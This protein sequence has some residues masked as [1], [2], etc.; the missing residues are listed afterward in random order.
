[1]KRR[2]FIRKSSSVVVSSVAGAY[3]ARAYNRVNSSLANLL[4]YADQSDRILVM[5]F[6]NGGNDGLNTVVPLAELSRLSNSRPHVLLPEQSLLRLPGTD[7]ALHPTMT[8][9]K[10]LF[11]EG[12]LQIIQNVGYENPNFSHFRS[13]D[14]W[15][16]ASASDELITNGWMGRYLDEEY[17]NFPFDYPNQDAPDPLA[18]EIGRSTSLIFQGPSASMGMAIHDPSFFYDLIENVDD[19]VPDGPVGERIELIRI[20]AKQSEKYSTR[21]K[22]AAERVTQQRNYPDLGLADQLKIVARLIAGGLQTKLYMVQLR[23]FDTHDNQVS[24]TS[25]VEGEHSNLLR[26][27]SRSIKAFTDDCEYLGVSDRVLGMTFS[28]FGRRIRSNGSYGTDHGTAAPLFFFGSN[29]QGGVLGTNP[30][31]PDVV[32]VRTNLEHEFEFRQIYSSVFQQWF[33]LGQGQVEQI[34]GDFETLPVV[35][36]GLSCANTT[37]THVSDAADKLLVYPSP[38]NGPLTVEFD[39]GAEQIPVQI[40]GMDGRIYDQKVR[41][42]NEPLAFDLQNLPPGRYQVRCNLRHGVIGKAFLKI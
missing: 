27:V 41:T 18:I 40:I 4:Q 29:I 15:M 25:T 34:L 21:V 32:N 10:E 28:E 17:P 33:C 42:Q 23:G 38:T 11:E 6:L 2:E 26:E 5:V 13:T 1:M 12:K 24:R 37:R 39:Y 14:I 16:S 8:G 9:F 7:L 36:E 3:G 30:K 22:A 20:L 31:V 19:S 35:Q